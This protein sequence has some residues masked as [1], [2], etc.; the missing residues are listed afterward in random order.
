MAAVRIEDI[1]ERHIKPLPPAER[2]RLLAIVAQDLATEPTQAT[3]QRQRSL[4]ELEGL[5]AEI[6][7]GIDAQEYVNELRKEWDHRP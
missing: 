1:Y 2:L 3:V 4:L 7:Q 6:W 5:G